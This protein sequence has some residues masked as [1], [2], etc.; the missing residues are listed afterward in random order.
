MK[1]FNINIL[2]VTVVMVFFQRVLAQD[3]S[4]LM[5]N[6]VINNDGVLINDT[7]F[8]RTKYNYILTD[9]K[10]NVIAFGN[11]DKKKMIPNGQWVYFYNGKIAVNGRYKNGKQVGKWKYP[12]GNHPKYKKGKAHKINTIGG[13]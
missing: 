2:V 7:S 9:D 11:I 8:N 6:P 4:I 3:Y 12:S 5:M 13:F 1:Y 10:E